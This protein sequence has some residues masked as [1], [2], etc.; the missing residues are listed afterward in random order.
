[1]KPINFKV[2]EDEYQLLPHT[3]FEAMDLDR[4]VLGVIGRMAQ[5]GFILDDEGDAFVAMSGVFADMGREDFRWIVE[6]TLKN[7]TV[8]TQ[9]KKN[10]TLSDMDAVT[11]H[12]EGRFNE[13]YV[14]LVKV[15]KE[16]KLSPFANAPKVT[17]GGSTVQTQ[18]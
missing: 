1:M 3:G 16:E 6:T 13:I 9:G 18:S 8:V 7:V 17:D 10:V 12:F 4:K 5:T 15:W 11:A 14:L 2:G